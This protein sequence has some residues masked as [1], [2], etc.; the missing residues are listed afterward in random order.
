MRNNFVNMYVTLIGF[1]FR[2]WTCLQSDAEKRKTH[3]GFSKTKTGKTLQTTSVTI[4][5]SRTWKKIKRLDLC[6][7]NSAWLVSQRSSTSAWTTG[8]GG[9]PKVVNSR[10]DKTFCPCYSAAS[11]IY[12]N[13]ET[14][15]TIRRS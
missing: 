10:R 15:D 3:E 7:Q 9:Q 13:E 1:P 2:L 5:E 6:G 12:K 14:L 8:T 4:S 11:R